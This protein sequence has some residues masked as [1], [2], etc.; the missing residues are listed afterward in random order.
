MAK[1]FEKL[2]DH[3]EEMIDAQDDMWQEELHC[4]Y[5]QVADIKESRYLPA[6]RLAIGAFKSAVRDAVKQELAKQSSAKKYGIF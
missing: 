6:K 4:N 2:L 1:H 3:I 5:K